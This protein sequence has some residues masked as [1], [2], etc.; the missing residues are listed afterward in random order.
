[1]GVQ[2][3]SRERH[4]E[5]RDG[6]DLLRQ[7]HQLVRRAKQGL[8]QHPEQAEQDGHLHNHGPQAADRAYSG[9]LVDPHGLLGHPGP[10]VLIALLRGLHFGLKSAHGPHL[11]DLFDGEG[12]RHEPDD[13]GQQDDGYAHLLASQN[14][15]QHQQIQGWADYELGP[16]VEPR[17]HQITKQERRE[18]GSLQRR[19]LSA[20]GVRSSRIWKLPVSCISYPW[21]RCT[22]SVFGKPR[23][24]WSP[25]CRWRLQT[26]SCRWQRGA[27]LCPRP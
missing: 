4:G 24:P 27:L 26:Q 12:H 22:R 23:P 20:V 3:R 11:P 19:Y 13:D 21:Y 1:M 9:I 2:G 25:C 16:R 10:V 15:K 17:Q 7:S 14:V 8:N 6:I 18:P 5:R